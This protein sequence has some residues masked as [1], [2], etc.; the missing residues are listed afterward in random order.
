MEGTS[1]PC[2]FATV[3]DD[4]VASA[5]V[6]EAKLRAIVEAAAERRRG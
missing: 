1:P 5:R 6:A 3:A 2:G 4:P